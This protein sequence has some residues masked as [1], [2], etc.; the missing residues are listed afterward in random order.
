MEPLNTI[1]AQLEPK[2]ND[3]CTSLRYQNALQPYLFVFEGEKIKEVKVTLDDEKKDEEVAHMRMMCSSDKVQ[4]AALL[5]DSYTKTGTPEEIK[6]VEGQ[7]LKDVEGAIEC[8]LI[9]LYTRG[10]TWCRTIQYEKL[11]EQDYWFG[12]AGWEDVPRAEG[13]FANPFLT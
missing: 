1:K 12:D 10:G 11:D 7:D 6:S 9:F 8:I 13:R 2:L 3:A 5:F 4:A